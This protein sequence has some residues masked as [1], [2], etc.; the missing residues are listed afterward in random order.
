MMMM[1]TNDDIDPP[2]DYF[3]DEDGGIDL[4]SA[5][6]DNH[7]NNPT[8]SAIHYSQLSTSQLQK[9][10]RK[11][12]PPNLNNQTDIHFQWLDI[13]M[14]NHSKPLTQNPN[15]EKKKKEVVVVGAQKGIVP[16]IRVYGVT[17][18]GYSIVTFLHGYTPYG[19]FA[20]PEGYDL[21]CTENGYQDYNNNNNNN[22]NNWKKDEVLGKIRMRLNS[23]LSQSKTAQ[24]NSAG[25]TGNDDGDLVQGVQYIDDK[26]SIMGYSTSHTK[27][28]KVYVQT[29]SLVPTLKRIM[30]E[31]ISLPHIV[32][33]KNQ[34]NGGSSS[35]SSANI[36][37][38]SGSSGESYQP[39]ECNVPFVLRFMIDEDVNGA[40]WITLP[41]GTYQLRTEESG[42]K[43]SHCQV[44]Y[45][46]LFF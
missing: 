36:W 4:L 33:S 8:D 30:E 29:P 19:Y 12:T 10:S 26:K 38:E 39:F 43:A 27:F 40:G 3:P 44:S 45:V 14:T 46:L 9:W 32:K 22:N 6:V 34:N 5:V 11:P 17:D 20:L 41:K 25:G 15:N 18:E 2:D 7:P 28:L 37:D 21:E 35:S 23:L 42:L 16:V 31:G 13:D 24:R 1:T